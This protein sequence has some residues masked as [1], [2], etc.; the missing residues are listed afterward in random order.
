ME[1]ASNNQD[2]R[3]AGEYQD[4]YQD[5]L[6]DVYL[7]YRTQIDE[8]EFAL[9]KTFSTTN[10]AVAGGA[11]AISLTL[12]KDLHIA[13]TSNAA[14]LLIV[15]WIALVLAILTTLVNIKVNQRLHHKYREILDEETA[16]SDMAAGFD[17]A[18]SRQTKHW[19]MR[20][21]DFTDYQQIFCTVT[22]ITFLVAATV[23][24]MTTPLK[25][26]VSEDAERTQETSKRAETATTDRTEGSTLSTESPPSAN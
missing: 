6:Y 22:G 24:G 12:T 14:A 9:D 20:V 18:R 26:G 15:A 23:I 1:D 3:D 5:Q 21:L 7:T 25:T 13:R 11:L 2:P 17:R 19:L 10:I 16:T 8:R 4:E